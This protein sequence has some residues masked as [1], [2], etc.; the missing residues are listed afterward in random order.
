MLNRAQRLILEALPSSGDCFDVAG[1]LIMDMPDGTLVHA[2]VNGQGPLE[3]I[4]MGH[5]WVERG[6]VVVDHSN[7]KHREIP[8]ELY[9][10]IGGVRQEPGQY[11]S[12]SSR[13]AMQMMLSTEHFG[14]WVDLDCKLGPKRG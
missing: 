10:S 2:C 11:V 3:G 8:K 9:Y 6:N 4:R 12:Y 7:G 1:R 14:P 5:A 13:E